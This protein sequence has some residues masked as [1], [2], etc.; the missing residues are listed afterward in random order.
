[1]II[2]SNYALANALHSEVVYESLIDSNLLLDDSN[3][4]SLLTDLINEDHRNV[5]CSAIKV[6]LLNYVNENY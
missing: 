2:N 1:M 3:Y 5:N 4:T 6:S